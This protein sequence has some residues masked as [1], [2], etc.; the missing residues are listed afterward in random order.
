MKLV[1][2]HRPLDSFGRPLL[3][4]G[5]TIIFALALDSGVAPA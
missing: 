1:A 5:V 3:A 2:T 4:L